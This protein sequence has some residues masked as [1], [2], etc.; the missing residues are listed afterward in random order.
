MTQKC[1]GFRLCVEATAL[2]AVVAR[3]SATDAEVT[4]LT[5]VQA[6]PAA[7]DVEAMVLAKTAIRM[8]IKMKLIPS[9]IYKKC[10]RRDLGVDQF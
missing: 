3:S 4:T 7:T 5:A 2:T 6:K 9:Y 8:A 1:S 10:T